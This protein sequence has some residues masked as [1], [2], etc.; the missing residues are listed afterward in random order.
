MIACVCSH[1]CSPPLYKPKWEKHD[2]WVFGSQYF[3]EIYNHTSNNTA[4]GHAATGKLFETKQGEVLYTKFELSDDWV[5]T[6][7]MGVKVGPETR[8]L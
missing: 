1:A 2:T 4:E 8:S 5:W 3:M 7:S 6:L